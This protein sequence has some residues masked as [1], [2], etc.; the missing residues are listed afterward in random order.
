MGLTLAVLKNLQCFL[1][2][3]APKVLVLINSWSPDSLF[4]NSNDSLSV[5]SAQINSL[6]SLV[7]T[8]SNSCSANDQHFVT[9]NPE[10]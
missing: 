3:L 10:L 5:F 6:I 7:V 9:V 2:H 1:P 4:L 8:D